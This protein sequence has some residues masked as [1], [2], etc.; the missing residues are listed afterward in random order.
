MTFCPPH[1]G[2]QQTAVSDFMALE[3]EPGK[4]LKLTSRCTPADFQ[5]ALESGE[6]Y[7]TAGVLV[8]LV[9]VSGGL[10]ATPL[11]LLAN[12]VKTQLFSLHARTAAM[13]TPG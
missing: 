3:V 7:R 10:E 1:L 4:L 11:A 8:S 12:Y 2:G 5:H 6:P 13:Q 9:V